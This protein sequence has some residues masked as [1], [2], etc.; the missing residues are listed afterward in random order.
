ME[1]KLDELI[2][3]VELT[4][5]MESFY[6]ATGINH[7]LLD[8]QGRVLTAVGWKRICTDF[9]RLYPKSCERCS[10]S[11]QYIS[12]RLMDGPYVGYECQN[13]LFDYVTPVVIDGEHVASIFTG[14]IFHEPPDLERFKRQAKEF[15][16]NQDAY[17]AAVREVNL[18]PRERMPDIM[19]F[20]VSLAQDLGAKGLMRRRQ[21]EA[22]QGL[23]QIN[24][25][26]SQRVQERAEELAETNRLLQ[27]L[28]RTLLLLSDSNT[29]LLEADAEARLLPDICRLIV[30]KGGYPLAWVG[31]ADADADKTV[32]PVASWGKSGNYLSGIKMSWEA[33]TEFGCGPSGTAFRTGKTQVIQDNSTDPR[34]TPWREKAL[35]AGFRSSI[36]LPLLGN[37]KVFGCL[38]I[39]ASEPEAFCA[40]EV[41]LL[42]KL[43]HNLAFG[44]QGLRAKMQLAVANQ[45]LQAFTYAASHDLKAPL[46]RI[47]SFSALLER[48]YRDR[49]DGDGL[50]FLDFIRGNATRMSALVDDMLAHAQIEQKIADLEAVSLQ[51]V[52]QLILNEK[53]SEIDDSG[54]EVRVDVPD[55]AVQADPLAFSQVLRNLVDNALKYSAQAEP[56]KLEIGAVEAEESCRLWVRDNGVGFD[57]TYH[58]RIFEIFTRL[59]TYAE[60]PGSGVGL[61]LVKK[62]MERM[63]GRVWAESEAGKGA[64]FFLELKT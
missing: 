28:N 12:N 2:D 41:G 8:R 56:P 57:M 43:A 64:T 50:L 40:E 10:V 45:E 3:L 29:L 47:V 37:D 1:Y 25:A 39:Y 55:I 60:F 42:E 59:H 49:L 13:G 7:A 14:Q 58:D 9:H 11:D 32:R 62:A 18:T 4:S 22:Q 16:F 38:H 15:G 51:S 63:N 33:D 48:D 24:F 52:V 23:R 26:L 5:L 34:I 61:A 31:F 20:L 36:A 21:L 6:R 30:E 46:T 53:E 54:A 44:I 27:R 19:E 35:E 17:L